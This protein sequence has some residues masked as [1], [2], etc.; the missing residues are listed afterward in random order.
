MKKIK[1][2]QTAQVEGIEVLGLQF[3]QNSNNRNMYHGPSLN[4]YRYAEPGDALEDAEWTVQGP[5]TFGDFTGSYPTPE[6]AIRAAKD[7]VAAMHAA[8]QKAEE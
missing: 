8:L 1:V 4:L 6:Q 3:V 2:P 5:D 7:T